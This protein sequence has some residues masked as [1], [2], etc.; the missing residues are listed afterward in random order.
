MLVLFEFFYK[1]KKISKKHS[2]KS[3]AINMSKYINIICENQFKLGKIDPDL[4]NSDIQ[5]IR[6]IAKLINIKFEFI[7]KP[8]QA[9]YLFYY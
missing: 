8:I 9:K 5:L 1:M 3:L 7:D 2:I 4:F 6:K